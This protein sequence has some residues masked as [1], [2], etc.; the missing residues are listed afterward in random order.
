MPRRKP[1]Y[2]D[3]GRELEVKE[4]PIV[5]FQAGLAGDLKHVQFLSALCDP[6][7]DQGLHPTEDIVCFCCGS[8]RV[9]SC[10]AIT[11]SFRRDGGHPGALE[12]PL[13]YRVATA[14]SDRSVHR[15]SPADQASVVGLG[16]LA[17]V[18]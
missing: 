13:S 14:R 6:V 10:G 9:S 4:R 7:L 1:K 16:K 17:L 5:H 12:D 3:R 15:R 2:R 11:G 8:G 18:I